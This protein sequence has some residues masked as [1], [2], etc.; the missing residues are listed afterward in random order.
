MNH[1]ATHSMYYLAIL[2]P[3]E[4]DEQLLKYKHWMRDRFGCVTA[5]KSPAHITLIPPFWLNEM[6]EAELYQ[7]VKAFTS[8]I[9]SLQIQL[10]GFSHFNRRTLYVVVNDQPGLEKLKQQAESHFIRSFHTVIN[11]GDRPFHPHITIANRDLKP[12]DFIKA[13]DHFSKIKFTETFS[14]QTISLL[15]LDKSGWNSIAQ[16]RW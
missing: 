14:I 8:D 7:A 11:A 10:T 5:L 13:W 9:G 16:Q 6:K 15:K 4:I 12:S 1:P 3:R 2:C